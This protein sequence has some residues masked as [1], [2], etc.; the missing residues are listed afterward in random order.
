MDQTAEAILRQLVTT[1]DFAAATAKLQSENVRVAAELF[2]SLPFDEQKLLFA[3]LPIDFAGQLVG[4]LL[5][6]H[7]YVLLHSRPIEEMRS[8]VAGMESGSRDQFI[9]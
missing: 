2:V 7:A 5:Y 6:Y 1:G 4:H 8:I 3:H 9:D